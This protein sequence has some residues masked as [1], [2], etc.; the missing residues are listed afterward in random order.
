MA[1][2]LEVCPSPHRKQLSTSSLMSLLGFSFHLINSQKWAKLSNATQ[3]G[4]LTYSLLCNLLSDCE[5]LHI[6]S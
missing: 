6:Y 2:Y 5:V 1:P 3:M 4:L